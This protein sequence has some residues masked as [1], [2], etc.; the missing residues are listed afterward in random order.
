MTSDSNYP[1]IGLVSGQSLRLRKV[2]LFEEEKIKEISL[3][4]A[5][6]AKSLGGVSTGIGFWGSPEWALGGAAVLG[7]LEGVLSSEAR[8]QGAQ[9]LQTA[10][11][12]FYALTSSALLFDASQLGNA[13][14][15]H[16]QA[17]FATAP[18]SVDVTD[19]GLIQLNEFLKK[20]N[21][22]K[23]DIVDLN[24]KQTVNLEAGQRYIHN[25]DEFVTV[26]I[27]AGTMSIRWAHVVAY[28]P[29]GGG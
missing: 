17:W 25:G 7:L 22:T 19:F 9:L 13:H 3:L 16:P 1:L 4:R 10:G 18:K 28:A 27:D 6:A 12:Q 29:P 23:E 20:H 24:R 8:K 26:V 21:K 2:L 15:P 14:V 11:A 5:Q